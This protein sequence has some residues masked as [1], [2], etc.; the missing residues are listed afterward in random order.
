MDG[1]P[2]AQDVLLPPLGEAGTLT[3]VEELAAVAANARPLPAVVSAALERIVACA[4]DLS[5][6]IGVRER[7]GSNADPRA[8]AADRALDDAWG[9]LQ[10]WLL[11]WTRLA[12]T[13]HARLPEIRALYA[14]LFPRGLAFLTLEFKDQWTESQK[15]LD[16][17]AETRQGVLFEELGGRAFLASVRAAHKAYGEALHL[18]PDA[19]DPDAGVRLALGQTHAALREYVALLGAAVRVAEPGAFA[20]AAALLEPLRTRTASATPLGPRGGP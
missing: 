19:V 16:F 8:R 14:A 6:Q 13:A 10:C 3:L 9:A 1:S 20:R 18:L 5:K 11:G 17:L 12:E 2:R 15:R 4:A 7:A